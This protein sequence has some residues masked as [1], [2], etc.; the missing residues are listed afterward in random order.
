[1]W[2]LETRTKEANFIYMRAGYETIIIGTKAWTEIYSYLLHSSSFF[3]VAVVYLWH[4]LSYFFFNLLLLPSSFSSLPAAPRYPGK[5]YGKSKKTN[6]IFER[7]RNLLSARTWWKHVFAIRFF[8]RVHF[9]RLQIW[10]MANV[11]CA[12]V[13][14]DLWLYGSVSRSFFASKNHADARVYRNECKNLIFCPLGELIE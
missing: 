2:E 1:M 4:V 6:T 12:C 13:R 14:M 5:K 3:L 8:T 10:T 11:G 9:I 7:S